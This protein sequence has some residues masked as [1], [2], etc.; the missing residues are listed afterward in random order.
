MEEKKISCSLITPLFSYGAYQRIPELRTPELKGAMRY[1]YRI[2]CPAQTVTLAMDEAELFG[3]SANAGQRTG[4]ASPVRLQIRRSGDA[5]QIC[6]PG[7]TEKKYLLLHKKPNQ[8]PQNCFTA[9]TFEVILRYNQLM[10]GNVPLFSNRVDLNWYIDLMKLSLIMCGMGRRSRKGR[11]CFH[12]EGE[13][14]ENDLQ[15]LEWICLVL[16]KVAAV[17]TQKFNEPFKISSVKNGSVKEIGLKP[18]YTADCKNRPFIQKVR[19][20]TKMNNKQV[21]HF[22]WA[23]D[24]ECHNLKSKKY[25][26]TQEITGAG[27]GGKFASPLLI[28]IVQTKD[29]Y[30]P[31]Y[32]FLNGIFKRHDIDQDCCEREQ[33][34]Q[35]VED[36]YRGGVKQ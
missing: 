34:I 7:N 24:E 4:Y 1:L 10:R 29:G 25:E 14:F 21:D 19:M 15:I 8:Q 27:R 22:L 17:S 11:G 36:T 3:G 28:R 33:F 6:G 18:E 35:K 9:G 23:V 20:G 31:L 26:L 12:I 16:N 13:A 5:E 30:Y 32:I 2:A